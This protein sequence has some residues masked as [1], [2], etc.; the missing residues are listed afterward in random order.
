VIRTLWA[1]LPG[2]SITC[3]NT[4]TGVGAS[5]HIDPVDL[6]KIRGG[7]D[8]KELLIPYQGAAKL[9]CYVAGTWEIV[10]SRRA[11]TFEP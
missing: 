8:G 6:G 9:E 10:K 1:A 4:G 11:L 2:D 7:G 5:F 3:I